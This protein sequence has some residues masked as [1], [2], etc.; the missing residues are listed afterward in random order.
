M[1]SRQTY[2]ILSQS[3]QDR[4]IKF[5]PSPLKTDL[6]KSAPA[7][8][9]LT[10][11]ILPHNIQPQSVQDTSKKKNKT[12][13]TNKKQ[14]KKK[15][16][17]TPN[18][19]PQSYQGTQTTFCPSQFKTNLQHSSPQNSAPVISIHTYSIPPQSVQDKPTTFR[20][21]QF[22]TNL[23]NSAPVISRQTLKNLPSQF[24]IHLQNSAPTS[25]RH[26]YE[27]YPTYSVQ[28][29]RRQWDTLV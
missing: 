29:K 25:S 9:R 26:T 3:I 10:Y 13:K 27:F 17:K 19:L 2:T 14:T 8:S 22:K 28:D 24:K 1:S 7:I 18:K 5:C 23:Q 4:P 16:K 12:K 20:P 21:S 6:Q 15:K 11:N